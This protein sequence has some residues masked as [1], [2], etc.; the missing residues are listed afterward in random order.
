[1]PSAAFQLSGSV[2][3]K[4]LRIYAHDRIVTGSG[5]RQLKSF[6]DKLQ[7]ENDIDYGIK[8]FIWNNNV[9]YCRVVCEN[10]ECAKM[11]A[12]AMKKELDNLIPIFDLVKL[13]GAKN[14]FKIVGSGTYQYRHLF[15]M[16]PASW[17][18]DEEAINEQLENS[19]K[20]KDSSSKKRTK[21]ELNEES[22]KSTK[23]WVIKGK[24]TVE[25]TI[26][27]LNKLTEN[28]LMD[29]KLFHDTLTGTKWNESLCL[30]ESTPK[31]AE[32][33]EIQETS[34][35]KAKKDDN[36]Q[37][38]D[39]DMEAESTASSPVHMV[40]EKEELQAENFDEEII[41]TSETIDNPKIINSPFIIPSLPDTQH[42][43]SMEI[44]EII[45]PSIPNSPSFSFPENC[46]SHI[47]TMSLEEPKPDGK[48]LEALDFD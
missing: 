25:K 44:T 11:T 27:L 2:V 7:E 17:I 31:K 34:H 30:E 1:M 39:E 15:P 38:T 20:K 14:T 6:V 26:K 29:E 46:L 8:D 9:G 33:D 10:S 32:S 24:E 19:T 3:P 45:L 36:N 43:S 47:P 5:V 42:I 28:I 18:S 21:D 41:I 4:S 40:V 12:N 37:T 22:P 23:N 13:E 35:K 48:P 16:L